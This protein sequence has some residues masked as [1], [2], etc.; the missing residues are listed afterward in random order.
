MS[1]KWNIITTI[2][3]LAG[4]FGIGTFIGKRMFIL[5]TLSGLLALGICILRIMLIKKEQRKQI[6]TLYNKLNG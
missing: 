2:L 4:G 6:L 3:L 5:A 1:N